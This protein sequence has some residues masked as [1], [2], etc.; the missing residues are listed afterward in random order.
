M[1][2]CYETIAHCSCLLRWS[3]SF[4]DCL[5]EDIDVVDISTP[6]FLHKKQAVAAIEAGKHVIIQKPLA[7]SVEEGQRI[8]EA[9][10]QSDKNVGMYMSTF[11]DPLV[12]DC[13]RCCFYFI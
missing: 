7:P 3:T 1:E 6:N 8:L 2:D 12:M 9:A 13:A 10:R 4:S 5:A 11:N